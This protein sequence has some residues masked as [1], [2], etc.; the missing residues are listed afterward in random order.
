MAYQTLT[1]NITKAIGKKLELMETIYNFDLG[2]EFE[3][4]ICELLAG[5]LPDKYGVCRGFAVTAAGKQAGDDIIIFDRHRFPSIRLL[6]GNDFSRKQFIPIEA[7]YAYIEAK[8]TVL[9][10]DDRS[11]QS[12]K[13]AIAQVKA[14]KELPRWSRR[15][16]PDDPYTGHLGKGPLK[17]E[18]WPQIP[19]PMYG[20]IISRYAKDTRL[21]RREWNHAQTAQKEIKIDQNRSFP[22][23]I[24]LGHDDLVVPVVKDKDERYYESPFYLDEVS[25]IA[26]RHI[27]GEAFA[28]AIITLL[29]AL[30]T[31]QLEK[32]PFRNMVG[33]KLNM[34]YPPGF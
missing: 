15:R 19:N 22:D 17:K 31:I 27:K 20:M 8:H 3:I 7:V 11:R 21:S 9:V 2:P 23:L 6:K 12:L 25:D 1:D 24:V 4:A 29:Y 13:K 32:M 33:E 16:N 10:N 30:D 18:Y 34:V 28:V 5:I 14:V 26:H